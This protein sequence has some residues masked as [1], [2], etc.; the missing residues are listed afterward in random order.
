MK[1]G[2]KKVEYIGSYPGIE[3]M[4]DHDKPEFCFIGRSN[5]GKSSLLNYLS[6]QNALAKTSKKPGK[7]QNINLFYNSE[8]YYFVDL[9]GY[10]YASISKSERDRWKKMIYNYLEKRKNL[11]VCFILIDSRI[12]FQEI[13]KNFINWTGQKNLPISLVFTKIDAVKNNLRAKHIALIKKEL[14]LQW[15][16]L[17]E[18]FEVSSEKKTGGDLL[19]EYINGIFNSLN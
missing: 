5:V 4:P 13:D 11:A 10:G 19:I 8:G 16:T 1:S 9:P 17:P 18:L 14:L 7:T 6:G 15:E 12:S 2:Q 3:K